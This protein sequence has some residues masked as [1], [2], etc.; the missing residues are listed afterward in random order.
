MSLREQCMEGGV[1][2]SLSMPLGGGGGLPAASSR[3]E[4]CLV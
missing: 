2:M 4:G 1:S 3:V